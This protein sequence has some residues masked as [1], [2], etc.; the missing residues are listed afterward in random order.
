M[1]KDMRIKVFKY[2]DMPIKFQISRSK[3]GDI[4]IDF[5]KRL[6]MFIAKRKCTPIWELPPKA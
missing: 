5:G 4:F 2:P 3:Y 6:I 1:S